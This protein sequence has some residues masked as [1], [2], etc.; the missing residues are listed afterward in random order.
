MNSRATPR[1][2]LP[3]G[4]PWKRGIRLTAPVAAATAALFALCSVTILLPPPA[5]FAET[6][7]RL[8]ILA[9]PSEQRFEVLPIAADSSVLV[10]G[11]QVRRHEGDPEKHRFQLYDHRL[12]PRWQTAVHL[13][14]GTQVRALTADGALPYALCTAEAD[15]R[16]LLVVA[17]A[18]GTGAGRVLR[19]QLPVGVEPLA[20]EVS[21]PDAFVVATAY[22]QQTV[23]RLPLRDSAAAQFLPILSSPATSVADAVPEPGGLAV[24]TAERL[25]ESSRLLLRPFQL[26]SAA[27]AGLHVLQGP[28]PASLTAGRVAPVPPSAPRL[29]VGTYATRDLRLAQGIFSTL[30]PPATAPGAPPAP[31]I[32]YYDLPTLPHYYDRFGPRRRVRAAARA[33]RR[34]GEGRETTAHARLLLHRPLPLPGG[35][36]ALVAEQYYPRYRGDSW[37][38]RG[39]GL[40]PYAGGLSG[41]AYGL[42]GL[43]GNYDPLNV[44]NRGFDGYVFTQALVLAFDAAGRLRWQNTFVL[45]NLNRPELRA[46][47][48]AAVLPG[49]AVRLV[50]PTD[51]GEHLRGLTLSGSGPAPAAPDETPLVPSTGPT[52]L[53]NA[54]DTRVAA[55]YGPHL[56]STGFQELKTA[57]G[58]GREVFVVEAVR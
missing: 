36:H 42:P 35:G 21:G 46:T 33:A 26:P 13:P 31:P 18:A 41:F 52:H 23:M 34:R 49:G 17:F 40:L 38:Y 1:L 5:P 7:P 45:N 19:Y 24:L 32:Y 39:A 48:A 54:R 6:L 37:N 43:Y 29:V 50:A 3:Q 12:R 16:A 55:W 53:L 2:P 4:R 14:A 44:W 9:T 57:G 20:F 56:L 22:R 15:S 10:Y 27:P 30:L 11:E 8:E 28:H 51:D 58:R 47:T 25:D